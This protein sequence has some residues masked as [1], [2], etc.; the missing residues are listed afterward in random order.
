FERKQINTQIKC[1]MIGA[2]EKDETEKETLPRLI[3]LILQ[4]AGSMALISNNPELSEKFKD[5]SK[6][7]VINFESNFTPLLP[8]F[9]SYILSSVLLRISLSRGLIRSHKKKKKN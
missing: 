3:D 7:S 2:Y 8:I 4:R 9:H 1:I 6:I 5:E